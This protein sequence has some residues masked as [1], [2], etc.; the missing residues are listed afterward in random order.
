MSVKKGNMYLDSVKQ[1]NLMVGCEYQCI[2]CVRSFQRQMKRQKH[3]C[4]KCYNYEPHFHPER[5]YQSLPKTRG[6]EFIWVGSSG[7]V[8]FAEDGWMEEILDRIRELPN[9]TFFFQTKNPECFFD[10]DFPD[11]VMLGVTLETNRHYP[12]ISKAPKP[13]KRYE[14]FKAISDRIRKIVTIEPVIFFDLWILLEW[15]KEINPIRVYIGYDT[16]NSNLPE[17]RLYKT[18][19]LCSELAKFT[20]VKTK[21]MREGN[22]KEDT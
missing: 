22:R 4:I 19:W 2:Y 1:W 17:P 12:T 3:N 6:D 13:K 16:K 18:F 7:D 14:D 11:N 10:Y 21:L 8:S 9:K 5:L 15:I 20:K